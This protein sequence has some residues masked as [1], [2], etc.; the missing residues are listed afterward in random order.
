[1]Q[2]LLLGLF[3]DAIDLM[4]YL[5][6]KLLVWNNAVL[7]LTLVVLYEETH[8][9]VSLKIINNKTIH[10][11]VSSCFKSSRKSFEAPSFYKNSF[12][13]LEE[14]VRCRSKYNEQEWAAEK[15]TCDPMI[16]L[17]LITRLH[18]NDSFS[19]NQWTSS[20]WSHDKHL[21]TPLCIAK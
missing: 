9:A 13:F 19:V 17:W 8:F 3:S 1:M 20:Y 11:S 7:G 10:Q 16:E 14:L 15:I 6:L 4:R 2:S 5:L 21:T 12:P 18:D